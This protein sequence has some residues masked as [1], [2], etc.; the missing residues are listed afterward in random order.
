MQQVP[1]AA[2]CGRQVGGGRTPRLYICHCV[3]SY[4]SR[5]PIHVSHYEELTDRV[6]RWC[7]CCARVTF[8]PASW[9]CCHRQKTIVADVNVS[10]PP[11][12]NAHTLS[13]MNTIYPLDNQRGLYLQLLHRRWWLYHSKGPPGG[14][15]R[16]TVLLFRSLKRRLWCILPFPL[17][18]IKL[19][20]TLSL[21][22]VVCVLCALP[23][24][25]HHHS[26]R[27]L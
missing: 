3:S 24:A 16:C 21:G 20:H 18:Y 14:R 13:C 4:L 11:H 27:A 8:S 15:E 26:C 17:P 19:Y 10:Q 1:S 6:C 2:A 9:L 23:C 12:L 25:V 22:H 5:L 7:C